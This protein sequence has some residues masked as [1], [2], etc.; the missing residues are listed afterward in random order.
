M[1]PFVTL[2]LVFF[3]LYFFELWAAVPVGALV[4]RSE[5]GRSYRAMRAARSG[6]RIRGGQYL[7]R[8]PW[9]PWGA[10]YIVEIPAFDIND[11]QLST[12]PPYALPPA[13]PP[14]RRQTVALDDIGV[15]QR[16]ARSLR[17]LGDTIS[18]ATHS[19]AHHWA[20]VLARLR[21]A[22]PEKRRR[23]W[24]HV[25][26][27]SMDLDQARRRLR[28]F[29]L[30]SLELRVLCS[31]FAAYIFVYLTLLSLH[32]V[33]LNLLSL[34]VS[35]LLFLFAIAVFFTSLHRRY[36]R[37]QRGQRWL[38]ALL[39]FLSPAE[40]MTA[41]HTLSRE[42]L[43][44]VHPLVAARVLLDDAGFA[45]LA[46]HIL[47]A[48]KN[49]AP[50]WHFKKLAQFVDAQGLDIENMLAAPPREARAIRYCP[51]CHE[52]LTNAVMCCPNCPDVAC[53]DF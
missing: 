6:I 16:D 30:H 7:L 27:R 35:Y 40:A 45:M 14:P 47:R 4:F 34:V 19:A 42:I 2:L 28:L 24:R 1:S 51:R 9:L 50:A 22:S 46:Q 44:Q 41:T 23:W 5:L 43:A 13:P 38:H 52:Q 29:R 32:L 15:I 33:V 37:K 49:D 8:K 21:Q 39:I 10:F 26:Q 36:L 20:S 18:C 3:A 31:A 25:E 53:T 48:A 17:V 11:V 12:T